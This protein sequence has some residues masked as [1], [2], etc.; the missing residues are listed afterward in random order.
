MQW[1]GWNKQEIQIEPKGF[2]MFGYGMWNHRAYEKRMALYARTIVF[3][4]NTLPNLIFCCLDLGCITHAIRE[5]SV[6]QLKQKLGDAFDEHRLVLTA[7]HTHSGPGGCSY[8]AMYSLVTPGFVPEHLN[9]V[10]EAIVS[11]VMGALE[12]A[13][14]TE[15]KI[16]K[17]NFQ[18]DTPVAWNRSI[19]AYNRNPEVEKRSDSET[20]LAIDREMKL[21]GF[22]RDQQLQAFI[23]CFGVHATCLG[24][25]LKAHD[26]D[27]K[28]YASYF[29]ELSLAESGVIE[30][31]AI[32]S[33]ATAGDVS[34]HFHGPLQEKIRKKI[35]GEDEYRYAQQNGQYQSRLALDALKG[36]ATQSF[37]VDTFDA[38]F[39]YVKFSEVEVD[40]QFS[41]GQ[42]ARTSIACHGAAFI[43]GT[44]VDGRGAAKPLVKIMGRLADRIRTKRQKDKNPEKRNYY[45]ALYASQG[46]KQIVLET[47][48]R[49]VL[50]RKMGALPGFLDPTIAEMNRQVKVGAIS[51]FPMVPDIIPLQLVRIGSLVLVCCPGEITT[52]AGQR[53]IATVEQQLQNLNQ[54]SGINHVWLNSYCNDYMGYITTYEEYQQQA[55]EGGHT[56]YG[57]WTLAAFQTHF[58]RMAQQLTQAPSLRNIDDELR[59][60]NVPKE[61]LARRTNHGNLKSAVDFKGAKG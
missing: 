24:N 28:G 7:T 61:E 22:Y 26:G 35:K 38:I 1:V 21:L 19:D 9:A 16:V 27:N 44:P 33:Q 32:F 56:I 57:Q 30:P 11:S 23:S 8:E 53:L 20:H 58:K 46:P 41:F 34:P 59:P 6:Q 36:A 42:D 18:D 60:P 14:P 31:V 3:G 43:A 4:K 12:A 10:V 51:D 25:T 48:N 39:C 2:A 47:G 50:D 49:L 40:P 17:A 45:E 13:E 29:S 54:N 52:I 15:I 5:Q 37:Q 55:Y